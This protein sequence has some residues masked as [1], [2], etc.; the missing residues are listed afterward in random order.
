MRTL[1]YILAT[2]LICWFADYAAHA[3]ELGIP[4]KIPAGNSVTVATASENGTFILIGP[5]HVVRKEVKAGESIEIAAEDLR[6][7]GRYTALVK[8]GSDWESKTFF[9]IPAKANS[10]VF[11]ARPSRVPAGK[12]GVISG[13]AFVFDQYKNFVTAPS[14]VKFELAVTGEKPE[15][16]AVESKE[17]IAW[18]SMN[19]GRKQGAA[20]F[21]ASLPGAADSEPIRRVVQQVAADACD[22]RM[23]AQ[24]TDK[25]ILVSTAPIKDCSGNPLPDGTIVTFWETD[26]SGRSTIDARVKKDIAQAELPLSSNAT[27]SVAS[28]VVLGNEVHIG[29]GK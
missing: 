11:L 1:L 2:I 14:Q 10:L 23:T 25:A 3:A 7:A 4:G 28:G 16:R 26:A 24:R 20:Q 8:S 6:T 13:V 21:V 22:I 19:S 15:T 17:G 9:V 5:S 18:V 29:G 12:E 27:I